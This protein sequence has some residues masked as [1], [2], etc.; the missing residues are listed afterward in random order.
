MIEAHLHGYFDG[1][2]RGT[3]EILV[4]TIEKKCTNYARGISSNGIKQ[5]S[6]SIMVACIDV[7]MR[8]L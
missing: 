1:R 5:R 6:L 2:A 3:D 8:T 7:R 4:G